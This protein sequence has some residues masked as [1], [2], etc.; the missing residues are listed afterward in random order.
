MPS[1]G[2]PA[3][4]V[5]AKG[6]VIRDGLYEVKANIPMSGTWQVKVT[7]STE[8]EPPVSRVFEINVR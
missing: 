6:Q 1:M 4:N 3:M 8:G 2:M 7:M 5:S